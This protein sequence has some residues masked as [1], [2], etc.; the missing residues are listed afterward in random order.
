[1]HLTKIISIAATATI[2]ASLATPANAQS[3]DDRAG[4]YISAFTGLSFPNVE[5]RNTSLFNQSFDT[6]F[7]IGGAIGYKLSSDSLAGLRFELET[8]YRE[9]NINSERFAAGSTGDTSSL[10]ALVNILYDFDSLSD[11]FI[12]Y[13]GVG[14]GIG[15]V[16]TDAEIITLNS[17]PEIIDLTAFITGGAFRVS[18]PTRTKFLYQAIAGV[19]VPLSERFDLFIDGR[20]Y[21]GGDVAFDIVDAVGNMSVTESSYNNYQVQ[22][23]IRL[24][25]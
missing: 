22:A 14:A 5:P 13:I 17:D 21:S 16:E 8:S 11:S 6:G 7:A 25:F 23:G 1:M 10:G 15:G 12:P 4:V 19:T 20:Y 9:S 3:Y 18:G 2:A 24:R